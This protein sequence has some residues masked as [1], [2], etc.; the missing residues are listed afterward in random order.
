[1]SWLGLAADDPFG[2]HNLPYGAFA[3]AGGAPRIGVRIGSRVL[4]VGAVA[5]QYH[6]DWAPWFASA[7]LNRFLAQGRRAWDQVRGTIASWVT[8]PQHEAVVSPHVLA[9]DDV[10]LHLAF[11][12]ADYVD[13]YSSEHH[14]SNVGAIFRPTDEPLPANWKHLPVAYHGRAGT[15]M[16]SGTDV[17]R[18]W[19]QRMPAGATLPTLGPSDRLDFEAEVG[20]VVGTPSR[21]GQ[22]VAG[23]DAWEHVFGVVLVNDWS[24]RDIQVWES[25]P[26]GPLSGKSFA[27][28]VSAWVTP[29]AALADAFVAPPPRTAPLLDYLSDD[30]QRWALDLSLEVRVNGEVLSRPP[31][32]T[33]YWTVAQQVA[34]LTVNGASLRVGDLLASGTVSGPAP[35]QRGSLLEMSWGGAEPVALS[36]GSTR[37]F[38]EDGDEVVIAATAP[39]PGA[40]LA[41][42]EVRGRIVSR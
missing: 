9:L 33:M 16:V 23:R 39:G 10:T 34:H 3:V 6:L 28:S 42:G 1:M 41:L 32:S 7:T 15:V 25:V 31:F 30:G 35:D 27:T 5:S 38:L 18:P 29:V 12:V 11:D 22:P 8:D 36:D 24:A 13:F 17:V 4:D 2:V 37:A 14:A 26:L 40:R 21:Q 19:G 20:F